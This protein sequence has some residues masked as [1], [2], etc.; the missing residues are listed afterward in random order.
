[1]MCYTLVHVINKS[2]I[3]NECKMVIY[4]IYFVQKQCT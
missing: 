3:E 1:M 4:R 2:K